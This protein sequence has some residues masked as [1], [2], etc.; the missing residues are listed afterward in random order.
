MKYSSTLKSKTC[1]D[2]VYEYQNN[3]VSV[4]LRF[5]TM[6]PN[7]ILEKHMAI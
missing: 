7:W 1:L 3:F 6:N 2:L 4:L 5:L